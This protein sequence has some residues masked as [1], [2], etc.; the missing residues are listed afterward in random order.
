M[1]S[2]NYI[3]L[4]KLTKESGG[5]LY[6]LAKESYN[7]IYNNIMS[8]GKNKAKP[9]FLG[10]NP[11]TLERK[12]FPTLVDK[13]YVVST[14]ADG[15]RFLLMIGDKT[16]LEERRIFFIDRNMDFWV[17]RNNNQEL[18]SIGNIPN[19]LLDGEL[20]MF[21]NV[22]TT[23]DLI[24]ITKTGKTNPLMV[25]ST[26]DILYGPTQP[27]IEG[28]YT[29]LTLNLGSSGAFMGPKGGY[30]WPWNKRYSVLGTMLTNKMSTLHKYNSDLENT[31]RFKMVL[32]PFID[33]KTVLSEKNP[34]TYMKKVF[35][36]SLK[37]QFPNIPSKLVK[38]T[39][40][41]ILT[42]ASTEYLKGSWAFCGN[43][44]FKWKPSGE[45]TVDLKVGKQKQ[46]TITDDDND[47]ISL[48]V[49]EGYTRDGKK[50]V[51]VGY[52]VMGDDI[53][54]EEGEIIE[55]L[56]M[57]ERGTKPL[58]FEYKDDR[59]DKIVPNAVQTVRSV[60]NAI[61]NPFSMKALQIVY[62]YGVAKLIKLSKSDQKSKVKNEIKKVLDQLPNSLKFRCTLEQNPIN[63]FNNK[64]NTELIKLVRLTKNTENPELES[65]IV[66]P[67]QTRHLSYFNCLVS[68][69]KDSNHIQPIPTVKQFYT[70]NIRKSS[71]VLG[72]HLI[73]E[74]MIIKKELTRKKFNKTKMMDASNYDIDYI[75]T[76]LSTEQKIWKLRPSNKVESYRY[77]VRYE[78]D[79][80][81]VSPFG[82]T[83]SV[84]WRLD[85]TEF[86]TSK[87]SW[88]DAKKDYETRPKSS[89]E[90]EFAPGDQENSVWAY[91]EDN[92]TKQNLLNV[93][94]TFKLDVNSSTPILV[95]EALD[96]RVSKLKNV[97]IE[98]IIK[99]YCKLLL[100]VMNLI[101]S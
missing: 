76:V 49:F 20:L 22:T 30:R 78:V 27:E 17:M 64:Q 45:L 59:P 69:L 19:C 58:L 25:Y 96:D 5:F 33:L 39:D 68:K 41:L 23:P 54:I 91:Y 42:P 16:E 74:E 50:Q 75:N 21:G 98:F 85:I 2:A 77:Q 97:S 80:L 52:I 56:W 34:Y 32:S 82:K 24:T 14:K 9:T 4:R 66:F 71:V 37:H 3:E 36:E 55:C 13:Q 6:P 47:K 31:F 86:G 63:L 101:Y 57:S 18:P 35:S 99:D 53:D 15:T 12:D 95:K 83:P 10:G 73:D 61:Q 44:Q 100:F 51:L 38:K 70:H 87:K 90:L 7:S 93:V 48:D 8:K 67:S 43:D 88:E 92:P 46:I 94:D 84:L 60:L 28:E 81:P 29:H 72:N 65:R 79:P 1:T 40:G 62:K 89:I 11:V 26:F